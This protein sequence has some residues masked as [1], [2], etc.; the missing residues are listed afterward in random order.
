MLTQQGRPY[1]IPQPQARSEAQQ[2]ERRAFPDTQWGR[3][4]LRTVNFISENKSAFLCTFFSLIPWVIKSLSVLS[5][6]NF[7]SSQDAEAHTMTTFFKFLNNE[8]FQTIFHN[9]K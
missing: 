4:Q 3:K 9:T 6:I 8:M 5:D 1:A 2:V 7:I